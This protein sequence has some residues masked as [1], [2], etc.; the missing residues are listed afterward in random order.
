M[1]VLGINSG[2]R[3][4]YRDASAV[5]LYNGQ[6]VAAVEE[7]RLNRIKASPAE[8]PEKAIAYVLKAAGITIR[9]VSCVATHGSTW[10]DQYESVLKNFLKTNFGHAPQLNRFHHHDCHAAGTFYA[11][12]FSEA[13]V[14]TIDN[15]GDG[16]GTQI[17]V[18]RNGRL[19]VLERIPRPNSLGMFYGM[20][21]QYCGFVRDSDEYKLMGLVPYGQPVVDLS[22]VLRISDGMFELNTDYIQPIE[23]GQPQPTVQQAIYSEKLEH[24]LGKGRRLAHEPVSGFYMDVAA[25]AQRMLEEAVTGILRKYIRAT[26]ISDVC[27]A[28]GVALNCAAN[29]KVMNMPEVTGL[30]VQPAAGDAG[31][32][33]GAAY[34]SSVQAG[35][36]PQAMPHTYWGPAFSN[37]EIRTALEQIGV[38]YEHINDPAACAAQLVSEGQVIAWM[39]GHME[40]GPRAL[41]NRSILADPAKED[42]KSIVNRKIKFRESFRPFC[43][44]V[45]EQDVALYF[46]GK[47]KV[48]PYMTV[49]YGTTEYADRYIPGVVHVDKTSRIQ[50][51]SSIQNPLYTAYLEQLRRLSGHGVSLNTSFNV[52]HQPIVNTPYE[53]VAT[54]Y[55]CG[56]DAL[57]IGNYLVRK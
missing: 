20:I 49:N 7:E 43:P 33:Q 38:R 47:Q 1:Y 37:D 46:T 42:I 13:L 28:G 14:L 57:V 11:S 55:S 32:S 48:A 40:F 56:L 52:N 10:G 29:K 51:V 27:L 25:S 53:A 19:E 3:I 41:G 39:Q 6:I 21:T 23:P 16:I 15:S 12:G 5:L 50:T 30:F 9:D 36:L 18:G 26:G 44:S 31:I 4:G 17:A 22:D 24:L 45:L 54:L 8:L 2:V 35:I 34:L